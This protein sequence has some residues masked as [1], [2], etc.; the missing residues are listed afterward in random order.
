MSHDDKLDQID[1]Y[2]AALETEANL[3]AASP[4]LAERQLAFA[5]FGGGTPSLLSASRIE[6]LLSSLQTA[7]PWDGVRE[8]TFECAPRSV[9]EGKLRSLHRGGVTRISLGVQQMND[10]VLRANGRVHLVADVERAYEAARRVGFDVVNI[11]LIAGLVA[12]TDATFETSLDRIID[13]APDSVT[14]YQLEIP[15]NTPLWRSLRDGELLSEVAS[16]ETKRA[17]LRSA[18]ERLERAGFTVSSAYAAVRDRDR[19]RFLYQVEQYHGADLLGI[20]TSAFSHLAGHNQQNLTSLTEYLDKLGDGE[21]PLFRAY[22][23]DDRERMVRE[24]ILQLKLGAVERRYFVGKFGVDVVDLLA[25]PL[26]RLEAE[27]WVRIDG[28]RI[29]LTREG[30]L[31]VDRFLPSLYLPEHRGVRYT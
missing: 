23:S 16:W 8:V 6:R 20:G 11:D 27:G 10:E 5:Y 15:L 30:L 24:L 4:A 18:M 14:I 31:R 13:M 12:E 17:R 26:R 22:V 28:E 29:D 3:Y 1:R 7:F 25:D 21:L 2:L 9:T 19:H